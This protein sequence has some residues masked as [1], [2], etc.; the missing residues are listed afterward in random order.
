[1]SDEGELYA[2]LMKAET[3]A[4]NACQACAAIEQIEN[5]QVKEVLKRAAGGTIG[6][7]K[8]ILIMK[9]NGYDVGRRHVM[10]HRKEAHKP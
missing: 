10:R 1:M 5:P 2:Q 4:A 3:I 8:F 7:D 6:R 9:S